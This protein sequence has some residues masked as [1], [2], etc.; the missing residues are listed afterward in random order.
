MQ[1]VFLRVYTISFESFY[2]QS[3]IIKDSFQ[4]GRFA[5]E[6][7]SDRGVLCQNKVTFYEIKLDPLLLVVNKLPARLSL[8]VCLNV[9]VC[10][11]RNVFRG[12]LIKN[13]KLMF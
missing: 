3:V 6:R 2:S 5:E 4:K 7:D 1:N 10:T 8:D 9:W 13:I 11:Y 12:Q